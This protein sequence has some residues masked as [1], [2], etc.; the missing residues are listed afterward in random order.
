[1]HDTLKATYRS[2]ELE[3]AKA[4][5][6]QDGPIK[7][8]VL[9]LFKQLPDP[10]LAAN[11]IAELLGIANS[12]EVQGALVAL[13]SDGS[14]ERSTTTT[15]PLDPEGVTLYRLAGVPF[16]RLK[17][18][19]ME[20]RVTPSKTR[21]QFT[22]DGRLIRPLARVD[23]LDALAGKGNQRD[24]INSHVKKIAA[25]IQAGTQ[26]PN[27]ILLTLL[28]DQIATSEDDGA[29]E[30]FVRITPLGE[31]TR[32]ASSA[33]AGT[34]VQEFRPV[35]IDFPYRRAAFDEEKSALLVDGQQRTAALS[36]VDVDVVPA[37][38]LSVNAEIASAEEAKAIFIVANST[39]KI[40]TQFSR[41][42]LATMEQSPGYLTTERP[43]AIAAKMLAIEDAESPFFELVQYPGVKVNRKPPPPVAYNSLFQVLSIFAESGLPLPEKSPEQKLARIVSR[44]FNLIK[45]TWP[46]AWGVRPSE[47]RLMHGVGL[48]S[49][50]TL[51]ASKLESLYANYGGD[52]D[53]NDMWLEIEASLRRLQPQLIW[54][55]A[56]TSNALK[57][58]VKMYQDEISSR[59]N[60]TQDISALTK[61][62]KRLSLDLD[63]EAAKA[64]KGRRSS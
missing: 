23:R 28:S 2:E 44:G 58:A 55:V 30:S 19:A 21:L 37:L 10:L 61:A 7:E 26:V 54:R 35:Q 17:I 29:P 43:R 1:M 52:L 36:L 56:D 25:G 53:H 38:Y 6:A 33:D 41:A 62:I 12:E 50:A 27:P 22:C 8:R 57:S 16:S 20:S 5:G 42:L 51:I 24:E 48:R 63:T 60:T 13:H 46:S 3:L 11:E 15:R 4:I 47:S 40:E 45:K 32:V 59:Q 49:M 14:V 39:A 34:V 9:Q 18:V 64:L 31:F